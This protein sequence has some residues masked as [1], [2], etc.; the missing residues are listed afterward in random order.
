MLASS[1]GFD[2]T[3]FGATG[4]DDGVSAALHKKSLYDGE[5]MI[6]GQFA[7]MDSIG[8][9]ILGFDWGGGDCHGNRLQNSKVNTMEFVNKVVYF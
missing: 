2:F 5:S 6:L 1:I 4:G 8:V 3:A 7:D 9:A